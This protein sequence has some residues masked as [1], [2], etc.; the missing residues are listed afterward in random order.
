M[1][2]VPLITTPKPIIVGMADLKVS[3]NA[4]DTLITYAL[5]SCLGLV[6]HDPVAR[7]AGLLHVML[8]SSQIDETKAR[9]QPGMFVDTGVP[10]LF[11][12]C[13]R[14][15]AK[16]ERMIISV[17]GGAFS[18]RA[19]GDDT[20]QIG[21]RNI[22]TLRKLLW[23]NGVLIH[24]EETGG[25]QQSRTMSVQVASGVVQLRTN[26]VLSTLTPQGPAA[27]PAPAFAVAR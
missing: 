6:V 12:E 27:A 1:T 20:F 14:F 11:R 9:T 2:A 10:A 13:Y 24:A 19:E 7:V 3:A 18:G 23:K 16:K 17:A 8:S 26:G 21:K 4:E 22:L 25:M 15:G 5:G